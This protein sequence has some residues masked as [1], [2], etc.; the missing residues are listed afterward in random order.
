MDESFNASLG[1]GLF[2]THEFPSY[3]ELPEISVSDLGTKKFVVLDV[4][5]CRHLSVLS[6]LKWT[7]LDIE[8]NEHTKMKE[9]AEKNLK[10]RIYQVDN[11]HLFYER[12]EDAVL[13]KLFLS[14][15]TKNKTEY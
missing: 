10:G 2:H 9:W 12:A 15:G 14:V 1:Y 11:E 13:L 5:T 7:D 6:K 3:Y 4:Q 8:Y